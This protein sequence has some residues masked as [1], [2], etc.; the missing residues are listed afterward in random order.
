MIFPKFT[1]KF[2]VS[3]LVLGAMLGVGLSTVAAQDG[4]PDVEGAAESAANDAAGAAEGAVGAGAACLDQF[5]NFITTLLSFDDAKDFFDDLFTRNRCQQ[6]D[7]FGLDRQIESKM[8]DLRG[9]YFDRCASPNIAELQDDIKNLK[10][11]QYFI[12]HIM[13]VKEDATFK[14]DA[15]ELNIDE[16]KTSL[17]IKMNKFYVE[18]KKWL[19]EEELAEKMDA[20]SDEYKDRLPEYIDCSSSPWQEVADKWKEFQEGVDELKEFAGG[21]SDSE[22]SRAADQ[23]AEA[24]ERKA[25]ASA[26]E[27]GEKNSGGAAVPGFLEKL[28]NLRINDVAPQRGTQ[29]LAADL[30]EQGQ[31]MTLQ[32]AQDLTVF[33]LERHDREISKAELLAKYDLL[34][35]KGSADIT[36]DLSNR[37]LEMRLVIEAT[38]KGALNALKDSAKGIHSKQGKTSP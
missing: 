24:D 23:K 37:I 20:W 38:T 30:K 14:K 36:N 17:A 32:Q 2:A 22:N 5:S 19:T 7:I 11:E 34:Y 33:E 15:D 16:L 21:K 4:A 1:L 3:L 35:S 25:E 29:Q 6:D 31:L 12:R 28:V 27:S 9:M 8:K 26:N 18:K 13:P 10:M